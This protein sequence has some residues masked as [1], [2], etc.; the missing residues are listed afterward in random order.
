MN[1]SLLKLSWLNPSFLKFITVARAPRVVA[2]R[3]W[4]NFFFFLKQKEK[5]KNFNN[6][7][8]KR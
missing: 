8:L 2:A 3:D 7:K 6:K 5:E 1:S 4:S